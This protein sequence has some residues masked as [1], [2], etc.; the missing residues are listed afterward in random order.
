VRFGNRVVTVCLAA[1][2][3]LFVGVVGF[4]FDVVLG[5]PAGLWAGGGV[6]LLL[7]VV[8]ATA[9]VLLRRR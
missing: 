3:L 7:A 9:P 1:G 6:L 2:S 5:G 8:W 4:V